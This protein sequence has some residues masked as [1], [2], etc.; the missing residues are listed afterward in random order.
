MKTILCFAAHPDDLEFSCTGILYKFL[1]DG[2][3]AIFVILTNGENGFKAKS[4]SREERVETR[5]KE[6]LE[7]AKKMR[8]KDV[9]FL[10]KKDGFLEYDEDLRRSL[11]QI[12]KK[13]RPEIIFSFDP[14]NNEFDSLNLF[15]RDHRT[16]AIAVF[17]ACFAAKNNLMYPG[18]QHKVEKIYF[19]ATNKPNHF[20]DISDLIEFK[21][22][23]LRCHKSQF[24]D[25]SKV[26]KYLKERVSV[27]HGSYQ[28]CEAFRVIEV[29]QLT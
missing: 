28:Y 14:A 4:D 9:I 3:E 15:H 5:K 26:E 16:A 25:F 8:L 24:P 12:I 18:S 19:F 7:V 10:D 29:R 27:R 23:L 20:E 17:D 1:K 6:Q 22:E 13:Y 11:V 21:L 2:Y